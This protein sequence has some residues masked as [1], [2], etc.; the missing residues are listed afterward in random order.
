MKK[1]ILQDSFRTQVYKISADD[2]Q[3]SAWSGGKTTEICMLPP[4]SK[5]R[6][7]DFDYRISSA[8]VEQ[9]QS[10]FTSLPGYYRIIL[11][12]TKSLTLEHSSQRV[13]LVPYQQHF[14]DG[15]EVTKSYGRCTDFNLIFRKNFHG[16]II[17]IRH[18]QTF[19]LEPGSDA[20]C[21]LLNKGTIKYSSSVETFQ[22]EL[23]EKETL[24]VKSINRKT[25]LTVTSDEQNPSEVWAL[26]VLIS[27]K[28]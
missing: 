13:K 23:L 2:Y 16:E 3:V 4:T 9:E 12:L 21:Y 1:E 11:P 18:Q 7:N 28:E 20:V 24:V 15:G 14:F 10:N 25:E 5:Y 27:K 26:L 8:T 17:P 22:K 19:E 6:L